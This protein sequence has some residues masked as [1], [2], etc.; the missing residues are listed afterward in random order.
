MSA[1]QD[2]GSGSA[3]L[4]NCCQPDSSGRRRRCYGLKCAGLEVVP[5]EHATLPTVRSVC[6]GTVTGSNA[7]ALPPRAFALTSVHECRDI[8]QEADMTP[9]IPENVSSWSFATSW[10]ARCRRETPAT[11]PR[12]KTKM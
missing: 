7:D 9:R 1:F 11:M 5:K 3:S 12:T 10:A 8:Q 6:A 4:G 2:G